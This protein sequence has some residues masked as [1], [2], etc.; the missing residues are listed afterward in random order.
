[1]A[2]P[3]PKIIYD[4][5]TGPVTLAFTHPPMSK[6]GAEER[7]AVRHDSDTISGIRQSILERVDRFLTLQMDYVPQADEANWSAFID[8]ALGGGTFDYYADPVAAPTTFE[9]FTLDDTNWA[10]AFAFRT[11]DKFKLKMRRVLVSS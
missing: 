7:S 3:I 2:Y 11:M 4:P 8:Y 9:T 1:M 6:P 5:G 10:P